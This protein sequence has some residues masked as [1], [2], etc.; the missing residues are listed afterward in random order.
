M[1]LDRDM[2]EFPDPSLANDEGLLAVGGDLKPETLLAAY[3]RGIF[4]WYAENQ[5][6][7]WWSPNPR[8]VLFP[9]EFY[10]SRR[11]RRRMRQNIYTVSWDTAFDQVINTCADIPRRGEQGSWIFAEMIAAYSQMHALDY[12]HSVEV[13]RG[14]ELVGGLY[15]VLVNKVFFAESMFSRSIDASKMALAMLSERALREGWYVI[16]CQ[17]HT[18][19]LQRLGAREISRDDFM[20]ILN[21]G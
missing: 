7:L 5:P 11:L 16:D 20:N 12:A 1:G 4:P 18:D 19:H 3:S 14:E 17:F 8:M 2:I 10:C 9:A 6:I 15:G 21:K 13:W